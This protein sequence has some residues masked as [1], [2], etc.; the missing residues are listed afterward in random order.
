MK[1]LMKMK[2]ILIQNILIAIISILEEGIY[3]NSKK[4]TKV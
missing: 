4:K 2:N 3:S 1:I